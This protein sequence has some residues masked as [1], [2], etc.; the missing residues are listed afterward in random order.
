VCRRNGADQDAFAKLALLFPR[1]FFHFFD[2][3]SHFMNTQNS[4][5]LF[6]QAQQ[7][8]P[9]GVNSPVRAFGGVGGTPLFMARGAGARM[10]D[11]D[12]NEFIDYVGSWGP[13]IHGHAPGFVHDAVREQLSCGAS[14]G[15]PTG[16]EVEMAGVLCDA[17]PSLEMVRMVNSGTEAVMGA[18]RA[19]R[20]YTG[21]NKI[22]KFAGCYHGHSD[23]L[24]VQAGSGATTLG[25]PD[26]A[27]VT[28]QQTRNTISANFND[29]QDTQGVLRACRGDLAA[30][31]VEP[32]P[33]NMGVVPP[34][35]GFLEM[36]R[37]ETSRQQA[38]LI[39]DE[40]MTGFRLARGGYQQKVSIT[41]DLTT[42]G[43]IIGGG[44]PVGAYGG[45]RAIMECVAPSGPVYQA[46]TLSGNPVAMTAGLA[47]L[48]A[49]DDAAYEKLETLG[50]KLENGLRAILSDLQIPAQLHRVGSMWTLF[51]SERKVHNYSSAKNSDVQKFARFFHA[52][53][54]RGI[55]L[56]PSQFES[57]FISLAHTED[58]I[59]RTL[60]AARESLAEI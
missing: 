40:V 32:L 7:L 53:L 1:C 28:S 51:F 14:F 56:P 2:F 12:G 16:L 55:Y 36:L 8:M 50:A 20:G 58:D 33:A 5:R 11:E 21:K 44:F 17:V 15:A 43:K 9:G 37:D 34:Q 18:I 60:E 45:K 3:V 38:V 54:E 19:A 42:L 59:E 31:I 22:I 24:L 6:Q 41:P 57:A 23:G 10:W 39:F 27:G 30:V 46:G 35:I 52:M 25:V 47:T 29:V 13:L 26:S 49:L 48:G 4:Q